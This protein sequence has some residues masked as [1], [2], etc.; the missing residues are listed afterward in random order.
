MFDNN[1]P[2]TETTITIT[3]RTL[4]ESC[5]G[6]EHGTGESVFVP[7]SVS[8]R[9][10]LKVGDVLVASVI[11]N[12]VENS[13]DRTPFMAVHVAPCAITV[14]ASKPPTITAEVALRDI[15]AD[16]LDELLN[17]DFASTGEIARS[18]GLEVGVVRDRLLALFNAQK[19]VMASVHSRPN[20][21]RA[22]FTLW[23]VTVDDFGIQNTGEE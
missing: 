3:T 15:D 21:K 18:L 7:A 6:L 12:P 22:S 16:I 10:N 17:D 23:A 13:R 11:P 2:T 8:I 5:F 20:L 1:Q 19:V 14:H 9:A 4:S